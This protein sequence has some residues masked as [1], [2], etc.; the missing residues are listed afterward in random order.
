MILVYNCQNFRFTKRSNGPSLC[1]L[2]DRKSLQNKA[3]NGLNRHKRCTHMGPAY[4]FAP[5]P[6]Q[7]RNPFQVRN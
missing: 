5:I 4:G 7:I 3:K 6:L 2:Y 1:D